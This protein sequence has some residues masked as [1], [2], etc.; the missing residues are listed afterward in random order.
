MNLIRLSCVLPLLATPFLAASCASGSE[1]QELDLANTAEPIKKGTL[2]TNP[3]GAA[4]NAVSINHPNGSCSGTLLRPTWVITARH[5]VQVGSGALDPPSSVTV[6][7]DTLGSQPARLIL[8]HPDHNLDVAL[9]QLTAPLDTG[10]T[11]T[12]FRGLEVDSLNRPLD[13]YGYGFA[14]EI[15]NSSCTS[16]VNCPAGFLCDDPN[17]RCVK[18]SAYGN[19]QS[20]LC[21]TN[22]QCV[23]QLGTGWLCGLG[24]RCCGPSNALRTAKLTMTKVRR[25]TGTWLDNKTLVTSDNSSG[26]GILS[27]DSGG[28]ILG[29]SGVF[30]VIMNPDT[31]AYNDAFRAWVLGIIG[32]VSFVSMRNVNVHDSFGH[33]GDTVAVGDVGGPNSQSDLISIVRSGSDRGKVF[34]SLRQPNGTLDVAKQW[35]STFVTSSSQVPLVGDFNGDTVQDIALVDPTAKAIHVSTSTGTAFSTKTKWYSALETD[36]VLSYQVGD[37]TGDTL[38]DIVVFH[39]NGIVDLLPSCGTQQAKKN[40]NCVSSSTFGPRIHWSWDLATSASDEPGIGDFNG[41]GQDD[42]MVAHTN[43]SNVEVYVELTQRRLCNTNADCPDNYCW[44]LL[45]I[46]PNTKGENLIQKTLFTTHPAMGGMY[47][48]TGDINRDGYDDLIL[49]VDNGPMQ[50]GLGSPGGFGNLV[51]W[52]DTFLASGDFPAIDKQSRVDDTVDVYRFDRTNGRVY[53]ATGEAY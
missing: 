24:S 1:P 16:D 53:A 11:L 50:V 31:I 25:Y 17:N 36:N 8:V 19:C 23:N 49:L 42:V 47:H 18:P 14:D 6:N 9:I 22:Q 4:V 2:V 40:S 51:T 45:H 39:T 48:R 3:T 10:K 43:G 12:V 33:T 5:C 29:G 46:C 15:L 21:T 13:A 37:L 7:H 35:H 20:T 52:R 32:P 34:V 26:Q 28:G 38:D 30:G 27:G 41:D 44:D